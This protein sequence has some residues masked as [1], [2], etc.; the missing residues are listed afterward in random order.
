MALALVAYAMVIH[1]VIG[2]LV[3]HTWPAMPMLGIA[4]CPT[5]IF[6][7]G[8]LLLLIGLAPGAYLAPVSNTDVCPSSRIGSRVRLID[9]FALR[10]VVRCR[11]IPWIAIKQG[12]QAAATGTTPPGFEPATRKRL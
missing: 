2:I 5:T 10:L 11:R 8:L 1:P 6:T 3:G 4:P 7:I 12:T 9:E